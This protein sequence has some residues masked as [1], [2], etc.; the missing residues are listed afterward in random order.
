MYRE[1]NIACI[2]P[3]RMS[4][5]RFPGKPLVKIN[6]RELI[7]RVADIPKQCKYFDRIIIATE[8]EII[9]DTAEQWGFEAIMTKSHYT[10]NHRDLE[11][12]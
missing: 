11:P 6:G 4:S 9:K 10:C 7:L 8:D 12:T 1:K 3:A 5:S 2:V